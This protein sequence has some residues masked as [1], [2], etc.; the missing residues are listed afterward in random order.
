MPG[1]GG[2]AD[3]PAETCGEKGGSVGLGIDFKPPAEEDKVEGR[4]LC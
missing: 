2:A 4:I 3:P 1:W